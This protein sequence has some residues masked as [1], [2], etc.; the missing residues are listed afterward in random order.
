MFS[1]NWTITYDEHQFIAEK[2][3]KSR[4]DYAQRIRYYAAFGKF[5]R[6]SDPLSAQI[7]DYLADQIES[8]M[9]PSQDLTLRQIQRRNSEIRKFINLSP[10]GEGETAALQAWVSQQPHFLT[11][12]SE[13]IDQQIR[14]WC[15]S[16]QYEPPTNRDIK[17]LVVSIKSKY[18]LAEYERI[19]EKISDES[20]RSL[21]CLLYT[22]D[23]ADE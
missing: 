6:K 18:D 1:E 23:A 11:E 8:P 19:I 3:E 4:L 7:I 16:R 10:L 20:V 22:S 2:P 15:L 9:M 17:R 5:P 14:Q 12:A 21:F 13:I